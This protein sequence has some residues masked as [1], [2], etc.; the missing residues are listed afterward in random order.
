MIGLLKGKPDILTPGLLIPDELLELAK[1]KQGL[2]FGSMDTVEIPG[3][4]TWILEDMI[5]LVSQFYREPVKVQSRW[6]K[7]MVTWEGYN[8]VYDNWEDFEHGCD[9]LRKAGILRF[10]KI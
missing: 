6:E 7:E 5:S 2:L 9:L 4:L 8:K 10:K 1:D 3:P